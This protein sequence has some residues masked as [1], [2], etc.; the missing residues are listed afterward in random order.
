VRLSFVISL[1]LL[2]TQAGY[3]QVRIKGKVVQAPGGQPLA[4]ASI[5]IAHSSVGV[6]SGEQGE[7]VITLPGKGRFQ[8]VI[9]HIGFETQVETITGSSPE[10]YYLVTLK[11]KEKELPAVVV[12]A[13][14]KNGWKNWGHLFLTSFVGTTE[15]SSKCE[16]LNKDAV[17]FRYSKTNNELVVSAG[18]PLVF[19]NKALGYLIEVDLVKYRYSLQRKYLFY[20]I[21]PFFKALPETSAG[22]MKR[23]KKH[24]LDAYYG[25]Q[26]H[27]FRS[28]FNDSYAGEGFELRQSVK[29]DIPELDRIERFYQS[30]ADSTG[31]IPVAQIEKTLPA[32]TVT[33]YHKIWLLRD[34]AIVLQPGLIAG[35]DIMQLRDSTT[36]LLSFPLQ[37]YVTYAKK[38]EPIEYLYYTGAA[39]RGRPMLTSRSAGPTEPGYPASTLELTKGIP[40]EIY[41]NGSVY[42]SNLLVNG[43]FSWWDKIATLLPLDYIPGE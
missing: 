28:L 10:K 40:V 18:E 11:E 32:D 20:E 30:Y 39:T 9:S 14:D 3:G 42:N 31:R 38:K 23:W 25:S 8:L 27:F 19:E 1:V 16:L 37:L 35:K 24:R 7:F 33:Y 15:Y 4:N 5:Y 29:R 43:F 22:D 17:K 34:S 6:A 2:I 41:R 12:D 13:Y 36:G 21:Y 26:M